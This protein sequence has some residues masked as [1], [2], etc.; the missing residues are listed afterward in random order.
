MKSLRPSYEIAYMGLLVA[1]GLILSYV[2]SLI[3]FF[4]G[5]P[6]MKLGLANIMVL[7]G[8]ELLDNKKAI[9]IN[10]LRI[11][12]AGF[13]FGNL[14]SIFYSLAGA[15]LSFLIM[16]LLRKWKFGLMGISAGGGMSH[17][18]GQ[19][20]VA[21]LV[22]DTWQVGYYA[23]VLLVFGLL[24]G[25]VNGLISGLTLPYLKRIKKERL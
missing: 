14:Y 5:V 7:F 17:N 3:P 1:L 16:V 6:G 19:L 15:L 9:G 21:A 10:V 23:P 20:L 18:I 12:L 8:M 11:L 13:L 2:E 25:L 22:V 4:F 24:T